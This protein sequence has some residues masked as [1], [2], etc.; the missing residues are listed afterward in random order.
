M[1]SSYKVLLQYCLL[2]L[3]ASKKMFNALHE[4]S[5]NI[6]KNIL[7]RRAVYDSNIA[8]ANQRFVDIFCIHMSF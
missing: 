2:I 3:M 5:C 1:C 7:L 4:Y 8:S 6:V